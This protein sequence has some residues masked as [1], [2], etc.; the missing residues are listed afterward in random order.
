LKIPAATGFS[1]RTIQK[2]RSPGTL[3]SQ[4][5]LDADFN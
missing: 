2:V 1:V 3:C 5:F 4:T